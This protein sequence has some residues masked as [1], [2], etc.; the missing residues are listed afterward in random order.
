[1]DHKEITPEEIEHVAHL[2]RLNLEREK[3]SDADADGEVPGITD[4]ERMISQISE[5]LD[6]VNKLNGL[7][8]EDVEPTFHVLAMK[9]VWRDDEVK[10]SLTQE[11][12]L[13]IA[14]KSAD[15][16]FKV[17]RVID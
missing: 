4:K 12:A 5:I 2:A 11:E 1:M 13:K 15:G 17:P 10:P 8:T 14:P 9:N 7:D 16:M 6:Y 3:K